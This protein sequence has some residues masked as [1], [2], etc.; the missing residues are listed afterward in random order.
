[1]APCQL[2]CQSSLEPSLSKTTDKTWGRGRQVFI[3]DNRTEDWDRIIRGGPRLESQWTEMV[4]GTY[5]VR[6]VRTFMQCNCNAWETCC[7]SE[8]GRGQV[9]SRSGMGSHLHLHPREEKREPENVKYGVGSS[10]V[11]EISFSRFR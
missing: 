1:M 6:G 9:G 7:G 10:F 11:Q 4:F 3:H 2:I 5:M 8:G